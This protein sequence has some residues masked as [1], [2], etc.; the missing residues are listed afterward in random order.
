LTGAPPTSRVRPVLRAIAA[1]VA[2]FV[3]G[4]LL[5]FIGFVPFARRLAG[6]L[7]AAELARQ[8]PPL[9]VFAQGAGLVLA[10]GLAT[11]VV[12]V[13]VLRLDLRDLRWKVDVRKTRGFFMGLLLGGLPAAL[14]MVLGVFAGGAAWVKDG[15]AATDFPGGVLVT[16]ALL[17]PAALAEEV[18]F[19]G[20]PLVVL[21]RL[22]GR[23]AALVL[24][25]VLFSL[26]HLDNPDVTAR[27]IGNVALAGIL[28]SLAFY[29][30][31]GM[32]TAFGA[33]L[34][35]NGTLASLGAPVS[36][37]PF[38]IPYIDYTMCGPPWLTGGRFGPEGGLLGT[39]A[40]TAAIV[41]AARWVRKEAS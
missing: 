38:D 9:F 25:S 32:W 23:P 35:W 8:P 27:A 7:T 39:I 13:K 31:G 30:P 33:H 28:L 11:W 3:L 12:G 15:G 6:G 4:L 17:A 37:L 29:S 1:V 2:F 26:A 22:I 24:L 20:V 21:A 16:V 40:I 41:V 18:M 36:G 19:R 34:G 5:F 10:F 14:A